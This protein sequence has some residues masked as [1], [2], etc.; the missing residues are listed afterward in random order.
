MVKIGMQ[1]TD[2]IGV[3]IK[4]LHWGTI[5]SV[6]HSASHS[7]RVWVTVRIRVKSRFFGSKVHVTFC[8]REHVG[9]HQGV[10][11]SYSALVRKLQLHQGDNFWLHLGTSYSLHCTWSFLCFVLLPAIFMTAGQREKKKC[12]LNFK[13]K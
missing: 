12:C 13:Y 8:I 9:L 7:H 3:Q 2:C 6:C 4:S 10:C 1:V 5:H 11:S